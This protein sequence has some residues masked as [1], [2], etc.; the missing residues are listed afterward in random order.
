MRRCGER[1]PS[2]CPRTSRR[3]PALRYLKG[4]PPLPIWQP[5]CTS[6]RSVTSGG[7]PRRPAT[8]AGPRR[9]GPCPRAGIW[10]ANARRTTVREGCG[11]EIRT[12]PRRLPRAGTGPRRRPRPGS[13]HRPEGSCTGLSVSR[14]A[15]DRT[16]TLGRALGTQKPPRCRGPRLPPPGPRP[17]LPLGPTRPRLGPRAS[18][19]A[20]PKGA[21]PGARA[22]CPEPPAPRHRRCARRAGPRCPAR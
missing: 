8:A 10:S 4:C 19:G 2:G 3:A 12:C 13:H 21:I 9:P 20:W 17:P 18:G 6:V 16:G 14:A 5:W 15:R 1:W 22:R 11:R 7:W